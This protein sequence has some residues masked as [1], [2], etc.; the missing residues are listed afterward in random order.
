MKPVATIAGSS[1]GLNDPLYIALDA[2]KKVYVT[3]YNNSSV[4]VY[5]AGSSGDV[6]WVALIGGSKTGLNLPYGV[7]VD[8]ANKIYVANQGPSGAYGSVTVYAAGASGNVKPAATIS[9]TNTGIDTP[10]GI[11]L[12]KNKN[13]YVTNLESNTVTVYAAGATGNVTP[14]ATISGSNT[15]LNLPYG[16]VLDS[17]GNIYVSNGGPNQFSYVTVYAAGANGNVT[18]TAKIA[19][20]IT[21]LLTPLGIASA[22]NKIYVSNSGYNAVTVYPIGSNGT[23]FPTQYWIG[24]NTQ[25]SDPWGIAVR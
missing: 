25:L 12:D 11:A 8:A 14:T 6:S 24:S 17:K 20:N 1:T 10:Q 21:G 7:A 2:T 16:I 4:T 5:A 22:N 13:I 18:P 23:V 3:N 19:G 9:G 15:G